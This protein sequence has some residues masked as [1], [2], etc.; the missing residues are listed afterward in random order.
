[1]P[2]DPMSGAYR[3]WADRTYWRLVAQITPGLLNSHHAY[4][5]AL[6][7]EASRASH[8]LDLG[9]GHDFLPPFVHQD[10]LRASPPNRVIVGIDADG[11]ALARHRGSPTVC[12]ATFSVCRFAAHRSISPPPTWW[13][14]TSSTRRSLFEEIARVLRPGGR[15][16]LHTP[17]AG[18]YTTRLTRLVPDRLLA[19]L[20]GA[21]VGRAAEDVYPT[22]YRANTEAALTRS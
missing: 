22:H 4:G 3:R 6:V 17:N 16:L 5:R 13:S 12:A 7:A 9:C 19:P 20:A 21:L 15:L 11:R 10:P 18:G 8:W 1:M 14:N 2:I